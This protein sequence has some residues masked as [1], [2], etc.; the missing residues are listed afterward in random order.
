M[1]TQAPRGTKDVTP[2]VSAL[3]QYVEA[4]MRDA[5][6]KAGYREVRTP[7]FEHTELFVRGVGDT[8]DVVQKEMYTFL[9]K[10]DRSVTLKPEGTAGVVRMLIENRLYAEAQPMKLYYL[11]S[12]I[13]RYEKPQ[14]G[15]FREHHQF[16][17]EAFGAAGATVDAEQIALAWDLLQGLGIKDLR[18]NVNSI[19]C[20]GCRPEY[21][22]R[23]RAFLAQ[24]L[25][26]L[27]GTCKERFDRN[28]MRILDCKSPECQRLITGTP[29]VLDCLCGE[30]EAHFAALQET[31]GLFGLPFQVDPGIVRGLDYYTKTVFEILT[32]IG[33]G[34]LAITGGGRYDLLVEQ[35]GGPTL[36]GVGFG[37]GMERVLMVMEAQGVAPPVQG[38]IDV[39]VCAQTPAA[40]QP[41][42]VLA[43]ALRRA[44]IR[45]DADH[46]ARS[47][48]AQF[49]YAD[50][51]AARTVAVLGEEELREG[52]VTLRDMATRVE[53]RV[54]LDGAVEALKQCGG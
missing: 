6:A 47:L 51:C 39:F 40:R 36:P 18:L 11:N 22:D 38:L 50:K 15:R 8:T 44:G 12:P 24:R 1:L 10:G 46:M 29:S 17:V 43:M 30:C 3:W 32:D 52:C 31:L 48:K 20:P 21:H 37:M 34:S 28:P 26:S 27:C 45:A 7:T 4:Q 54:P 42:M 19:G 14:S 9:D 23:L 35:L 53:S 33:G 5:C 25:E 13:F 49:K 41:A 2:E 16:G